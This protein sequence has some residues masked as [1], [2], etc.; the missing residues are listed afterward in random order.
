MSIPHTLEKNERKSL[1]LSLAKA[2]I[3]L[4]PSIDFEGISFSMNDEVLILT[5]Q[6]PSYYHKQL[7]Q[8]RLLAKFEGLIPLENRIIVRYPD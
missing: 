6:V 7:A 1:I 3:G 8:T 2:E 5:G 4:T